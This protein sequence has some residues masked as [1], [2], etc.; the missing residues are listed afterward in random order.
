MT[1]VLEV[2]GLRKSFGR[3][4]AVDG[5]DFQLSRGEVL[6]VAGPNGAG[7]S[8]L[9]NL[10]SRVPFAPDSGTV[11]LDGV[12]LAR[13]SARAV[14]RRGLARTFQ[15]ESAFDT[16]SAYD[17]VR[18]AAVYGRP[19]RASH[20]EV[21]RRVLDALDLVGLRDTGDVPASEL[22]LIAKKKLM[23]AS[24]LVTEPKVLCLDEPASGLIEP[25]QRELG[26]VMTELRGRGTAIIVVEHVLPLLR[27]VADRLIIM[28]TGKILAEGEP[29]AVLEHPDVIAAYIGSEA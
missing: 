12:S 1:T 26:A 21:R 29:A 8:T 28:A 3:L 9:I 13:A 10:L 14:C 16:L 18:V 25:E 17:N 20:D 4:T 22:P 11:L 6:G 15:A 7:K 5:I 27:A 19:G 24:A 23:I 2:T